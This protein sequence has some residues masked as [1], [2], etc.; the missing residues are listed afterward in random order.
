MIA[1]NLGRTK[2]ADD[3]A[4]CFVD[5]R[6]LQVANVSGGP[7]KKVHTRIVSTYLIPNVR[8]RRLRLQKNNRPRGRIVPA[9]V[10]PQGSQKSQLSRVWSFVANNDV[11]FSANRT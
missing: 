6:A 11:V 2:A 8:Y 3:D 9:H 7:D 5:R 1:L 4:A 10:L